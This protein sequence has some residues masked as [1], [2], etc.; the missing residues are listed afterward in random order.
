EG[1]ASAIAGAIGYFVL[2]FVV[3][4]FNTAL[5]SAA[6]ERLAGGDP[7]LGS[8]LRAATGHLPAILGW[9][10]ISATVSAILKAIEERAGFIGALVA[11]L[12]G[13]AW[14][15]VTYLVIPIYVVEGLG[16]ID[17]IKRSAELFKRTWGENVAASVGFGLLGF[18]AFLP[19]AL[20][21]FLGV[22]SGVTAVI[23][24]TIVIAVVALILVSITLSTLS[25]IFQTALY[26]YA[27][28]GVV[29]DAFAGTN[30]ATAFRPKR[31]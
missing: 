9:S 11:S 5:V 19:L 16:V 17:S 29:P 21:V 7:T 31:R 18:I 24:T 12:A 10:L 22:A 30:L 23:V 6:H 13:L 20:I 8:A 25:G 2:S 14:T 3:I 28:S 26:L 1:P 27:T 15:L 4:F